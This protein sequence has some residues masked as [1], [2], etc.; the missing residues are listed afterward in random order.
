[1]HTIDFK[2]KPENSW[3][4]T[5]ACG[6]DMNPSENPAPTSGPCI[7]LIHNENVNSTYV[8]YAD[9]TRH[10]WSTRYEVFHIFGIEEDYAENIHCA[11]CVPKITGGLGI[12]LHG[13]GNC[14]HLL[15]RAVVRGLLGVTQCTNTKLASTPFSNVN[16]FGGLT[17][18]VYLP[19]NQAKWG[20]LENGKQKVINFGSVY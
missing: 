17:V 2:F 11:Y 18:N 5:S 16:I 7:Y 15:I 13:L 8:G 12:N 14:E 19:T 4:M 10:R 1:V 3:D 20:D 9:N 6:D